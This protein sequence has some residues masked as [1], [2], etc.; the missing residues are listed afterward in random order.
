MVIGLLEI[1]LTVVVVA[2]AIVTANVWT[3]VK[4]A[5]LLALI[6]AV[7]GVWLAWP[8]CTSQALTLATSNPTD[9]CTTAHFPVFKMSASGPLG[10]TFYQ[11]VRVVLQGTFYTV[12]A[13]LVLAA[14]VTILFYLVRG[15]AQS[16]GE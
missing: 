15:D 6:P 5:G 9:T 11:A 7:L 14:A 2:V 8:S 13:F 4:W 1:A 10:S 12:L 16:S 3:L